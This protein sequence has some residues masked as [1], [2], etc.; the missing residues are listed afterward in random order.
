M[1]SKKVVDHGNFFTYELSNG[2]RIVQ[3]PSASKVVYCGYVF[4]VGTRDEESSQVGMAHFVEHLLFKGTKRHKAWHILNRMERV[5]GDLNAFTNKEETTIYS[6]FLQE[7]FHRAAELLTDIVFNSTFP[8]EEID[9]EVNVII[10]EIQS[11]ED[12]PSELIFDDFEAM[13]FKGHP[14]DHAI[15]GAPETLRTFRTEDALRFV[16]KYYRP[17]N[18]VFFLHGNINIRTIMRL[19]ERLTSGFVS[20]STLITPRIAPLASSEFREKRNRR[21]YQSHVLFGSRSYDAYDPRRTTLCLLNNILGGP[22]MNSRL[23]V[24]L[25]E[26]HALVYNVESSLTSYTDC[27]TFS[28]YY[29]A[30]PNLCSRC[31]LAVSRELKLLCDKRLTISQLAAA[32]RQM[33][34]Q[35]AISFDDS[36][37]VAM[38]LGKSVLHYNRFD[39]LASIYK[40]IEAVTSD[41][42]L[43]V[44]NEVIHPS[45]LSS[46]DYEPEK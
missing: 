2:L 38:D 20:D 14:L 25:R 30:D 12:T 35:L 4:N 39:S 37:S 19:L 13:L 43:E 41:D 33:I 9:K 5:G 3:M 21:V 16:R 18:C 17:D 46:I 23:N 27:G 11:Y 28:V 34:G 1:E 10:D 8:Q 26:K 24:S 7:H 31:S 22:G 29:A 42:L 6:I 36:E 32:K 45:A 44:A 40:R 15:L